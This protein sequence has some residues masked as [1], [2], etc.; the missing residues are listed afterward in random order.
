[1]IKAEISRVPHYP[2]EDDKLRATSLSRRRGGNCPN[3]LEVLSQLISNSTGLPQAPP[4]LSLIAV[5]PAK[6]SSATAFIQ[7][8]LANVDISG[9]IYRED[10][11]EAASSYIIRSEQTGSRTIVNF[12][13]LP[14]MSRDEFTASVERMMR[15]NII[16][17][18]GEDVWFHFEVG[19]NFIFT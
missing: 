9:C 17:S 19:Y 14:E 10:V 4:S 8:S 13:D 15:E 7:N 3:T 12:N 1:M 5:L 2:G 16:A 18:K 11:K 6:E